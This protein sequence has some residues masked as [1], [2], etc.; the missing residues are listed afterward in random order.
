MKNLLFFLFTLLILRIDLF[1]IN[2]IQSYDATKIRF[3]HLTDLQ[4]SKDRVT[5]S[6]GEFGKCEYT[7]SQDVAKKLMFIN[8]YRTFYKKGQIFVNKDGT[9]LIEKGKIYIRLVDK[10]QLNEYDNSTGKH[11]SNSF[12]IPELDRIFQ[13]YGGKRINVFYE[14]K[15][16]TSIKSINDETKQ[17]RQQ[18]ERTYIIDFDNNMDV[19]QFCIDLSESNFVEFAEPIPINRTTAVPNDTDYSDQFALSLMQCPAAWDIF[20][21]QNSS[22]EIVIG[23]CD[24]GV[25][26]DHPDLV[27]NL[28]HNLGE[29]FNNNG[30]VVYFN[31]SNW[32]FDPGDI[33]GID[34]DGN[35]YIDDFIGWNF[36]TAD[37]TVANNPMASI[38]NAHGT[39]VAGICNARTDNNTG[40]AGLPW[41]VKFIGTKHGDNADGAYINNG[42]GGIIYLAELG[43]DIINCSWGGEA[44]SSVFQNSINYSASLGA[45]IIAASGNDNSY[46]YFFPA[47]YQNIVSVSSVNSQ[48]VKTYY[49][50]YGISVDVS[51]YGGETNSDGGIL[52]TVP[53]NSYTKLQGTSMASPYVAGLAAYYKAYKPNSTNYDI[54]KAV[55][56]SSTNVNDFNPGYEGTL[57]HGIINA[58]NAITSTNPDISHIPY[59]DLLSISY[60]EPSGNGQINNGETIDWE[61]IIKNYNHLY[62]TNN[63]KYYVTTN[64]P[65]V[66]ILNGTGTTSLGADAYFILDDIQFQ[67]ASNCPNKIAKFFIKFDI[68]DGYEY[69][70]VSSIL[71][72]NSSYQGEAYGYV[73]YDPTSDV[74]G[75]CKFKVN[76]PTNFILIQDQSGL[77]WVRAGTYYNNL[78]YGFDNSKKL[79]T[80]N[81]NNGDRTLVKLFNGS[82]SGL[83]YDFLSRKFYGMEAGDALYNLDLASGNMIN[84]FDVSNFYINLAADKQGNLYSIDLTNDALYKMNRYAENQEYIAY[85]NYDLNYAQDLEYDYNTDILYAT[86]YSNDDQSIFVAIDKEFGFVFEI[87]N[88]PNNREITGLVFPH[89]WVFDGV[90]LISPDYNENEV[91]TNHTF[92]WNTFSNANSY[93]I[94][95]SLNENFTNIKYQNIINNNSIQ[96][97]NNTLNQGMRYFWRVTAYNNDVE[98]AA[99]P[100]WTFVMIMPNYC[101]ASSINCDEFIGNFAFANINNSSNCNNYSNFLNIIGEVRRGRTY[102]VYAYNPTPYDGDAVAIFIDWNQNEQFDS[103]S[104]YYQLTTDN[105]QDF[106]GEVTVPLDA[107]LGMTVL[108]A[109]IVYDEPLTPCNISDYG[110]VEDYSINVMEKLDEHTIALQ[111]GWNLISTYIIPISANMEDIWNQRTQNLLIIKNS[112]GQVFIPSFG[113]NN[114]GNWSLHQ[115]YLAYFTNSESITISGNTCNPD[116]ESINYANSWIFLSYIRNSPMNAI[117]AFA[118]LVDQEALLIAKNLAGQV[119]IPSFGINTIGNLLPGQAYKIYCTKSGTF[120]YPSN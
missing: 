64:D 44:Y 80:I 55:L 45:L 57:G 93:K 76:D 14:F 114:I 117:T 13:G 8:F 119:Y 35:G 70:Y 27:N 104:E 101:I 88:I 98:I 81:P 12:G 53:N 25:D 79:I 116:N 91:A 56:G 54:I 118:D 99:S 17:Y 63:F 62:G 6:S 3:K 50:N 74:R 106:Y 34:D 16:I 78:W 75:P 110:E 31:G 15:D 19:L 4:I 96:L 38:A 61:L 21:G 66:T 83:S 68:N 102:N 40:V 60:I 87:A 71:I 42:E 82:L 9:E 58:Y 36:Y 23:V 77:D 30:Y 2:K 94:E 18:L 84:F 85:F 32:V 112:S 11:Y 72:I 7:M 28:K 105:F 100:I 73:A 41:N 49:S 97:P 65:D 107:P 108:R 111:Q 39:H 115:G 95:V 120:K 89:N 86:L 20:K 29:D 22:E 47:S 26:W 113:I 5:Y 33:N 52:S 90:E 46:R 69:N 51:A 43:V 92:S 37:G 48:K 10:I 24:S 67:I 103:P 59:I 109:R 1:S